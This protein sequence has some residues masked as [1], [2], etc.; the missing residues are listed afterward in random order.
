MPTVC[1]H[2]PEGW[3][4]Q[5]LRGKVCS[6][7]R[8][9]PSLLELIGKRKSQGEGGRVGW[10]PDGTGTRRPPSLLKAARPAGPG[11]CWR[12]TAGGGRPR[13]AAGEHDRSSSSSNSSG[14]DGR[15]AGAAARRGAC[16]RRVCRR[17]RAR[18][19]VLGAGRRAGA[20]A[21]FSPAAPV[22]AALLPA[23][24][25]GPACTAAAAAGAGR[26]LS[27]GS[28]PAS[29]VGG[30]LRPA[31]VVSPPSPRHLNH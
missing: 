3:Q 4:R 15:R 12:D 6:F 13:R 19:H 17:A 27:C 21:L 20:A 8:S 24:L 22:P 18:R 10:A 31:E 2:S 25:P 14:G 7:P 11:G 28:H 5:Q 26:R 30:A 16:E 9:S 23:L 1:T 29:R